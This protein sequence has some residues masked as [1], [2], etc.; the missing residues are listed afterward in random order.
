MIAHHET[1]LA[2]DIEI[3]DTLLSND[4]EH[5][6]QLSSDLLVSKY[7]DTLFA[8]ALV[9]HGGEDFRASDTVDHTFTTAAK[10]ISSAD[11][12]L[13]YWLLQILEKQFLIDTNQEETTFLDLDEDFTDS[14]WSQWESDLT[15]SRSYPISDDGIEELIPTSEFFSRRLHH[16]YPEDN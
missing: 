16:P 15:D 11:P 4:P 9:L 10:N 12:D 5:I 6:K 2:T 7:H 3:L 14:S 8:R 1:V 13:L